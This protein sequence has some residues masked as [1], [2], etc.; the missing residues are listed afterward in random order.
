MAQPKSS[1]RKPVAKKPAAKKPAAKKPVARKP[2]ITAA[3]PAPGTEPAPLKLDPRAAR[4]DRS[5]GGD[6]AAPV[7]GGG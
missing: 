1:T 7:S 4:G 5:V 3:V 2:A 6:K